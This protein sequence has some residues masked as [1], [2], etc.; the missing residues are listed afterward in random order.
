MS[1][2]QNRIIAQ[3]AQELG[4]AQSQ[5]KAAVD[6]LDE[7]ATVP[8]IA[9][10]RKEATG[11]LD[12]AVLR[13]LQERLVYLRELEDRRSSILESIESQ[14]K[15][16]PELKAA[17]EK[18]E[19]KQ[20]LEDL[21]LPYKP[22]RRTRAQIAREAGLQPLAD[23]IFQNK[24]AVPE[25]LAAAYLNPEHQINDTKAALDGARDILAEQF[26]ENAALLALLRNRL[27]AEG[28]IRAAVVPEKASEAIKFQD[29]FEHQ[30]PLSST[31]SH[32]M[33]AM[34]RGRE[35]GFLTL[36]VD[37]PEVWEAENPRAPH[38][39]ESE[40]A[41]LHGIERDE[42]PRGKFL[43]ETCR[44][45]WKIKLASTLESEVIGT[46]RDAAQAEAITVFGKNLKD[47]LL[48]AP[49]GG[50]ATMGLDPG[51]RT[52]VKV[53]VIDSTGQVV[54]HATIYP[55]EPRRQWNESIALLAALCMKHNVELIAIGNGTASRETDQLAADLLA[56]HKD[57]KA[58]R[59]MV[60]EAGA[61]V[62]S[63]SALASAE[64]PDLDVSIRGAVSI[65]RRLQDPL[66]ELVK[67]DPKSIGVGQYQH[68][69]DQRQLSGR[70]DAVV[71]DCVNAV[72][73]EVN[74]ASEQLLSR[75][76]GLN[77]SVAKA[78]VSFRN[79]N[80]KFKSREDLRKVPRLGDKTFEQ[81]AGFLRIHGAE[82]PLDASSV[83][84]EAYIVVEKM[85]AKVKKP[86]GSLVGNREIL[87]ELKPTEFVD[88]RFGLPTVQDILVEL[89]KPGRDPRP[90]F[91]TAKFDDKV[92]T[93]TDLK[94]GMTLEG[95]VTNVANFGAFVDIGVHQDGLVHV[96]ALSNTF[97]KDP[98]SVVKTGQIVKVKV[99]EVDIPRKRIS[100]T[101]KMGDDVPKAAPGQNAGRQV[102]AN[103][104]GDARG[105]SRGERSGGSTGSNSQQGAG[106]ANN[107]FAAAFAKA[108]GSK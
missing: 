71:E 54:E 48:S 83:H 62:Y 96:S 64:L 39:F 108:K 29:Y 68:D 76:S 70:L 45:T 3:L 101:M 6:L 89:E 40:I 41:R 47:L 58:T 28:A 61:S 15:L 37:L 34:L 59:V 95:V 65:A 72:G 19:N 4:A 32:R 106:F 36:K 33:L 51:I 50:K 23:E 26:S 18:A 94:P 24:Q 69:V 100:L 97:V 44:W 16:T 17:I 9:R 91:K 105:N 42:S 22:K 103:R 75:V 107:A 55:H 25:T 49:A 52:G 1:L 10:Y 43:N 11:G 13:D 63:A 7:G 79:S 27:K 104:A 81:A 53:A 21:Y 84:P 46:L 80:G 74:T 60:S 98:H 90:S 14:G 85:A 77:A 31:A 2:V 87:K 82:N 8:F 56:Q 12:D 86:V 66:A 30:E 93:M 20:T 38:P 57:L 67:I 78:L 35:Q 5:I 99:L 73:V 102:Q 92:H 88:D